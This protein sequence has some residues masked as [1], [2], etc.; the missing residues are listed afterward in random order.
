MRK[1]LTFARAW[2]D[3]SVPLVIIPGC[4]FAFFDHKFS[5]LANAWVNSGGA[6]LIQAVISFH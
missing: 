1:Y 4:N 2:R 5:F 6:Q 3:E